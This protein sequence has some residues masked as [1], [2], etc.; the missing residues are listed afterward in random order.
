MIRE[1]RWLVGA[2]AAALWVV[3]AAAQTS[4]SDT[5]K[6]E[7][8][9]STHPGT[10][11]RSGGNG[12]EGSSA[13]TG[14]RQMG[15]GAGSSA[16]QGTN[17]GTST[18]PSPGRGGSGSDAKSAQTQAPGSAMG[19]GERSRSHQAASDP[20]HTLAKLHAGNQAEIEAG[21]WMKGHAT[22]D[23][24]KDFAKK[25]VDDHGKMDKDLMSYAEKHR[26]DLTGAKAEEASSQQEQLKGMQGAQA[27]R[28]YMRMMVEDHTKDVKETKAAAQHAKQSKDKEFSKLLDKSAKTMEGHLKDAQKIQ[29]DLSQRQARTPSSQ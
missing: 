7:V 28:A 22:N 19:T 17:D 23:K 2:L 5:Q 21:N 29:R 20:T 24:V 1:K 3:P 14:S 4:S 12:P 25:M 15:T 26:I 6:G 13:Q 10:E 27:D 11:P 16:S 8:S 18:S 9:G